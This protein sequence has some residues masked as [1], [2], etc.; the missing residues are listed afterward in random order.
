VLAP[1]LT[2][3]LVEEFCRQPAP[4][5]ALEPPL[6]KLTERE[7]KGTAARRTGLS[8]REIAQTLFLSE[9]TVKTREPALAQAEGARPDPGGCPRVRKRARET[10]SDRTLPPP[11]CFPRRLEWL[12]KLAPES[13]DWRE[14]L[15]PSIEP[16]RWR[17][18]PSHVRTPAIG[19]GLDGEA[20]ACQSRRVKSCG[21]SGS[22]DLAFVGSGSAAR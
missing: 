5:G 4:S 8:N 7:L 11:P 18:S 3:R 14:P 13:A 10:G 21:L 12:P 19:R 9:A 20:R 16:I 6:T 2:R 22:Q 15:Q 1:A 17:T